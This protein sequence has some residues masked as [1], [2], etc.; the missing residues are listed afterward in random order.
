MKYCKNCGEQLRD[1]QDVC[2]HCGTSFG[3]G[4]MY[5][6]NCGKQIIENADYCIGCGTKLNKGAFSNV[7][8]SVTNQIQPRNIALC[9]LLS[10]VTC[11]IY[12]IY[13]FIKLT[14]EMNLLVDDNKTA[15]GGMAFLYSLITCG[16]YSFYWSYKMGDKTD[17]LDGNINGSKA[18]LYLVL[19]FLGFGIIVY[20][21]LQD[22]INKAVTYR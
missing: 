11:G 1:D 2:L 13:W 8:L 21:L 9:V 10:L 3:H 20:V 17:N 14:D 18:I 12:S 7:N 15:S 6:S 4:N 5:C 16:I 22:T 19:L